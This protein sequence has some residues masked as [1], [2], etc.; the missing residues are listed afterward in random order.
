MKKLINKYQV[1]GW[2]PIGYNNNIYRPTYGTMLPEVKVVA[3]GDPRKVNNNYYKA[4]SR[5]RAEL[6]NRVA[7]RTDYKGLN[8]VN[9][10]E[11][12]PVIG[13]A[14]DA[15]NIIN[16]TAN[17][18]YLSAGIGAGTFL[19]PNIIEKPL[20]KLI[21]R[22]VRGVT[23]ALDG[24]LSSP[25]SQKN[26]TELL[27]HMMWDTYLAN[28]TKS[29]T[30]SPVSSKAV[31]EVDFPE[32]S[33]NYYENSV[34][35]RM[36]K[37]P[38]RVA[39][40][41]NGSEGR[42][43]IML[44][45]MRSIFEKKPYMGD[46]Q[47]WN[48]YNNYRNAEGEA[49]GLY[50]FSGDN[51][52]ISP[53]TNGYSPMDHELRHRLQNYM[54]R[55]DNEDRLLRRAYNDTDGIISN[56]DM[57]QEWETMNLDG[58]QALIGNSNK[59]IEHQNSLLEL[60]SED[61][62]YTINKLYKADGYW[63]RYIDKLT[64]DFDGPIEAWANTSEGRKKIHNWIQAMKYVGILSLPLIPSDN[65]SYANGGPI[66]IKPENRGKFTALS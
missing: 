10:L 2:F 57:S 46:E 25:F 40:T 45:D 37:D 56:Y 23:N 32:S 16:D 4:H 3:K 11:Y 7:D 38:D 24:D 9:I 18:N 55:T 27:K 49:V 5:V 29:S 61:Y 28:P 12:T 19:L 41:S 31:T 35:P 59:D 60:T 48:A 26:T 13:D 42:E 51:I 15:G 17:R 1:G 52:F 63:K 43:S 21:K 54:P 33:F 34:F 65:N 44:D 58:R 20:K 14:L 47:F 30:L 50:S 36:L 39:I 66:H 64:K 53:A 22:G 6:Q 8:P 62:G